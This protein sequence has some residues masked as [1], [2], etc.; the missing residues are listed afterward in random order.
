MLA[1]LGCG[2]VQGYVVARPMPPEEVIP[3]LADHRSRLAEA[4]RIGVRAR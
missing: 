2:H 4:L 1:Q 3:W